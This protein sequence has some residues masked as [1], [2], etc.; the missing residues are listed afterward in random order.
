MLMLTENS[1]T[2]FENLVSMKL[3]TLVHSECHKQGKSYQEAV[4]I[5]E[6]VVAGLKEK[7]ADLAMWGQN[8]LRNR[9]W[10]TFND[11]DPTFHGVSWWSYPQTA[12]KSSAGVPL[13]EDKWFQMFNGAL[14]L[15]TSDWTWSTHT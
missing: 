6:R 1:R 4:E 7:V 12:P 9:V 13:D 3:A 11:Q 15:H 5:H 8:P 14:V 10:V 2:A